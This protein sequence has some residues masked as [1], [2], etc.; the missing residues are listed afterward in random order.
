MTPT[1]APEPTNM[2]LLGA[3]QPLPAA[4][5]TPHTQATESDLP[6]PL[7]DRLLYGKTPADWVIRIVLA[8]VMTAALAV[9]TW[10]IYTLLTQQLHA[11]Q[12]I[13]ILGCGMFDVAALFFA[14]L[15]Q[16]YAITTDSG[17]APR[18]AMLAMVSTSSWVNW[19][20]G[21][22]E[23][24]GIVGSV[25]LAAAPVIAELAFEMFHRYAHRETLR[26]L[27][28]VAQTLPVLGK[29]AWIAHPSRSR[30]TIDAHIQAALTEHEAVAERREELAGVRAR[31]TVGLPIAASEVSTTGLGFP[32]TVSLERTETSALETSTGETARPETAET[33]VSRSPE[34]SETETTAQL[35]DRSPETKTSTETS[36]TETSLPVSQPRSLPETIGRETTAK[37]SAIGDRETETSQLVDLMRS[38]GDA[39]K[40]SLNDAIAETG[41]P[42]ATA[43]KRLKAARDQYLAET[44]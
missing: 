20:H 15:S 31:L 37:V 41:R 22:L 5:T 11:P 44:A 26:R 36:E 24:W 35:V 23:G 3:W 21:Q 30:K 13:A 12:P 16:R 43:A 42:K 40:V 32:L 8:L 14:L 38:R 17:L 29:W 7:Y 4:G 6:N 25:I 2:P 28:R 1:P 27:G 33:T 34:T 39:M 19:Q 10:S 18:A 9:G